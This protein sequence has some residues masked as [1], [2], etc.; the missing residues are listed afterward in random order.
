MNSSPPFTLPARYYVDPRH[1]EAEQDLIFSRMWVYVGR[2][3]ELADRGDFQVKNVAGESLILVRDEAG[4][5]RAFHNVCRHRGTTLCADGSGQTGHR[6]QCPYHAWTWDLAGRL[7]AAPGMEAAPGFDKEQ[8]PL[9]YARVGVWEGLVFV[10]LDHDALSLKTRL[11]DL[12]EKFAPWKMGEL[13]RARRITYDVRANWKLII[14]NYSECLHCPVIHPAL[15]KLSHYLSGV[16]E[17]GG[18][19]STYLGGKMD[20]RPGIESM[21]MS[22][23]RIGPVISGLDENQRG[24]VHYYAVL[25]NLLL[26]LHPDY[27]MTH[28]L[29][30]LAVD[31][32][33][34]VCE[35]HV[36]PET[37]AQPLFDPNEAVAFWDLTNR[38]DWHISEISQTGIGSRAYEPGPYSPREELLR[39]FDLWLLDRLGHAPPSH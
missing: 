7:V 25:P 17:P 27:L 33:E 14:Q 8:Y 29:R 3:E 30:P 24:E 18:V 16:N 9:K 19:G 28:E 31:R 5:I 15:S 4:S 32:T 21:S 23:G 20:L 12:P 39:A 34:I 36:P 22:G 1:F 26:S 35:W 10:N 13:R 37:Q 6:I 38:Q 2:E 11:T